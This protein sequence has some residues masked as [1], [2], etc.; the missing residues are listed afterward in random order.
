[1]APGSPDSSDPA[2]QADPAA[3]PVDVVP[4]GKGHARLLGRRVGMTLCAIFG[5]AVALGP[6]VQGSQRLLGL[7]FFLACGLPVLW[8]VLRRR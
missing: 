4:P 8:S 2:R 1:M 5:L 3:L 7:L 6:G